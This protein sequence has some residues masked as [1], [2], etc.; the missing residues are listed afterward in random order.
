MNHLETPILCATA[1]NHLEKNLQK[2]DQLPG[3]DGPR[4][5]LRFL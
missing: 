2:T 4:A 3:A 5:T 1:Q